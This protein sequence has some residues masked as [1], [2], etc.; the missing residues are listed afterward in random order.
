MLTL[1]FVPLA[2]HCILSELFTIIYI[3]RTQFLLNVPLFNVFACCYWLRI[4]STICVTIY[5]ACDASGCRY[6]HS[7]KVCFCVLCSL[8]HCKINGESIEMIDC[9]YNVECKE[10]HRQSNYC[11]KYCYSTR[12]RKRLVCS[13]SA[14][15]ALLLTWTPLKT[16]SGLIG[17][18]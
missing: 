12:R 13:N 7:Y 1:S 10:L 5:T 4:D 14:C 15:N 9:N 2:M 17:R 16:L 18:P 8:V 11:P 6:I 3:G